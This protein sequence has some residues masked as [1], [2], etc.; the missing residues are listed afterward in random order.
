MRIV[1]RTSRAYSPR[2]RCHATAG[3]RRALPALV[4]SAG[5]DRLARVPEG[6][7]ARGRRPGACLRR[8]CLRLRRPSAGNRSHP[9]IGALAAGAG[10]AMA[11]PSQLEG[12]LLAILDSRV[13][14][15]HP[16]RAGVAVALLAAFALA[17][18]LATLRAQSQAEQNL[19]ADSTPRFAG[20]RAEESRTAGADREPLTKSSASSPRRRNCARPRW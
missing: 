3:A 15:T 7:R 11:R 4:Q 8:R 16:G 19:P 17:A 13:K 1:W 18:P 5:L 6:A 10:V 14:R 12:R 2:R 20:E 9:A